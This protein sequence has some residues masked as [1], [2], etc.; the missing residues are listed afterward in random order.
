MTNSARIFPLPGGIDVAQPVPPKSCPIIDFY[1]QQLL[2]RNF[3]KGLAVSTIAPNTAGLSRWTARL[4]AVPAALLLG[5]L[6]AAA[7]AHADDGDNAF[8]ASL[9]SEGITD[10]L[11]PSSA[12]AA[13]HM[14]CQQVEEGTSPED[15]LGDVIGST[16]MPAYHAGYFVGAAIHAYC[17]HHKAK[18]GAPA[19]AS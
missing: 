15:I 10:H 3:R 12:I 13:A 16:S 17:P 19:P 8:L 4:A 7:T 18:L 9:K 6:A 14:V 1:L 2:K 5:P 11:S